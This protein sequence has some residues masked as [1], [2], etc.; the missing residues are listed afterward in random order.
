MRSSERSERAAPQAPPQAQQPPIGIEA[1]GGLSESGD[2]DCELA[3]ASH[4]RIR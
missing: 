2:V 3:A 4:G 1:S